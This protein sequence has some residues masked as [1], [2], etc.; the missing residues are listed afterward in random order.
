MA[1]READQLGVTSCSHQPEARLPHSPGPRFREPLDV[2]RSLVV[3]RFCVDGRV[4]VDDAVGVLKGGVV[5]DDGELDL[6]AGGHAAGRSW[7]A[8][9]TNVSAGLYPRRFATRS[10]TSW[11]SPTMRRDPNALA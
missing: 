8:Q 7:R 9:L 6:R 1:E 2:V 3:R 11:A 10:T 5:I 4:Q